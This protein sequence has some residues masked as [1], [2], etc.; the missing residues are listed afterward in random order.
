MRPVDRDRVGTRLGDRNQ[1]ARLVLACAALADCLVLLTDTG[2]VCRLLLLREQ[3]RRDTDGARGVGDIDGA[4]FVLGI[5]LDGSVRFRGRRSANQQRDREALACHLFRD[6]HHLVE[7]WRDQSRETDDIDLLGACGL[8]DLLGRHHD[9]KI[10]DLVVVALEHDSDDVLADIVYISLDGRHEDL[11]LGLDCAAGFLGLEIGFEPG[12]RFLHDACRLDDLRQKHLAVTEEVADDIHAIHERSLDD[13][14]RATELLERFCRIVLD[15][16]GN[17]L[18]ERM[19]ETLLDRPLAPFRALLFRTA[20]AV[21]HVVR[22]DL[23][24]PVTGIRAAIQY[25]V[26]DGI[27]QLVRQF[28]VD[29]ELAGVD[30]AHVHAGVDRVVKKDRVDCLAHRVVAAEREGDVRDTARDHGVRQGLLDG[31]GRLDEIDAVVVVFLDTR[32]HGEDVRVEDDVLGRK[33]DLLR[34]NPVGA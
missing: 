18:D 12:D 29:G 25:H 7:R 3:G 22:R 34:K 8:E 21:T 16:L 26:L 11:A 33:T 15:V 27:A 2:Q 19:L 31:A 9:A 10:D 14:D 20:T 1:V 32:R 5:D 28:V 13:E 6:M 23:D 30:D 17:A 4:V 24:E